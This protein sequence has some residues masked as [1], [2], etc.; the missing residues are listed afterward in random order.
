MVDNHKRENQKPAVK[1]A[2][3]LIPLV[4]PSSQQLSIGH[5][6]INIAWTVQS[7][8]KE[9]LMLQTNLGLH[10]SVRVD[11]FD[12]L[13]CVLCVHNRIS[14]DTYEEAGPRAIN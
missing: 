4:Q 2:S 12:T 1:I 9:C 6:A 13:M 10:E 5:K 14:G 8:T 7:K 3:N 11:F